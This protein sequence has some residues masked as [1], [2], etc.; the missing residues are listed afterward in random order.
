MKRTPFKMFYG[1]KTNVQDLRVF[2]CKV[3]CQINPVQTTKLVSTARLRGCWATSRARRAGAPYSILA[4][5]QT[6][7]MSSM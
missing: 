3:F 4:R 1:T 5:W 2:G 7:T 6:G